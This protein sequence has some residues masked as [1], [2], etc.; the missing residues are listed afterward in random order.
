[1]T[2]DTQVSPALAARLRAEA[3]MALRQ[4]AQT[5]GPEAREILEQR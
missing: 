3:A 4:W 2:I 1:V 5:V